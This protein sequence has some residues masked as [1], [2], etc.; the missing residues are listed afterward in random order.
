MDLQE[1]NVKPWFRST[2]LFTLIKNGNIQN[3]NRT[4][5]GYRYSNLKINNCQLSTVNNDLIYFL[6]TQAADL[7]NTVTHEATLAEAGT[8]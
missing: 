8:S 2:L 5:K 6:G 7:W 3:A 1:Q 4:K